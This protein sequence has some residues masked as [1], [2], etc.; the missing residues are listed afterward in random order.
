[1]KFPIEW[2]KNNLSNMRATRVRYK[3]DLLLA[4]R[5]VDRIEKDINEYDAQILRAE[6]EGKTEFDR[7]R[8]NVKR[9][10]S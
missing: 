9:S 4:Q 3:N 5:E 10:V 1:M 6:L 7:E 8:F 2:H